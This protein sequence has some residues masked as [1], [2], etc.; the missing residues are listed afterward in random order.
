M[1]D[2]PKSIVEHL[3]ELRSRIIYVLMA[4]IIGIGAGIYFAEDIFTVITRDAGPLIQFN[5]IETFLVHLRIGVLAGLV[6]ALPVLLY[7]VA[8]FLLPAL[9]RTERILLWALLP[10]MIFLFVVGWL[11]GWFVVVPITR[12][13][14]IG[15]A[16]NSGVT[17]TLTPRT[18]VDFI[19][20]ICTPLGVVFE[21]PLVVLVLARIGLI[22]SGF[23]RRFRKYAILVLFILA[24]ILT[25]PT[26]IDQILLAIP[27]MFLYEVSIWLAKLVE[28]RR[29]R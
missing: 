1:Q 7:Q 9:T 23:L 28:K 22:T 6:V 2:T 17:S 3:V 27:M 10:G 20:S 26:V 24:A 8:R 18:Y 4:V 13:F 21:L 14:V 19:L 16:T 11:F 15:Y 25:P 12:S 5:P 29:N